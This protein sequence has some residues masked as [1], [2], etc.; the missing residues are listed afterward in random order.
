MVPML[1]KKSLKYDGM[2]WTKREQ[3]ERRT[4]FM[5][6]AINAWYW[7]GCVRPQFVDSYCCSE[8]A[9]S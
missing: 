6:G 8:V 2:L 4:D 7:M 9:N 5:R 3:E 1:V